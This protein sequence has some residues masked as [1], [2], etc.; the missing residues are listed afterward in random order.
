MQVDAN[1]RGR[2]KDFF[3]HFRRPFIYLPKIQ[4]NVDNLSKFQTKGKNKLEG[5]Q[6]LIELLMAFVNWLLK[7][8]DF[9][10]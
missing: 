8:L 10:F 9:L 2:L 3:I 4:Y 1:C 6:Q 7:L 5:L